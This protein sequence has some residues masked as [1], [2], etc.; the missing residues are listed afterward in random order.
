MALFEWLKPKGVWQRS[1]LFE[2]PLLGEDVPADLKQWC[3]LAGGLALLLSRSTEQEIAARYQAAR[4]VFVDI[5]RS[6]EQ[7]RTPAVRR[8]QLILVAHE[9]DTVADPLTR[10]ACRACMRAPLRP[11]ATSPSEAALA[12]A[13]DASRGSRTGVPAADF[14]DQ[15]TQL[16][17]DVFSD[18][19]EKLRKT[20]AD[21]RVTPK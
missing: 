12:R 13:L 11:E 6:L 15:Q 17:A 20:I 9:I 1:P 16:S 18:R 7:S 10:A 19:S 8:K 3:A 4:A 14:D 5:R 21:A 2:L